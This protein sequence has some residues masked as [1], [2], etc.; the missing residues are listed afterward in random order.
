M[1]GDTSLDKE[2]R[3]L[4]AHVIRGQSSLHVN[5]E[6]HSRVFI[7]NRE[8]L[9]RTSILR[10][11]GHEVVRPD[12]IRKNVER[13]SRPPEQSL[14]FQSGEREPTTVARLPPLK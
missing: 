9:H 1:L 8:P 2:F 3:Q 12:M 14:E 7:D 6:P 4:I 5:G 11:G 13:A 10:T